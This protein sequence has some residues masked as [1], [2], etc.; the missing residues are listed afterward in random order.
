MGGQASAKEMEPEAGEEVDQD[1]LGG[2][3]VAGGD[4]GEDERFCGCGGGE[5][6]DRQSGVKGFAPGVGAL[7]QGDGR[8]VM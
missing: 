1:D 3:A 4:L 5:V 7:A 2:V 6:D 8:E